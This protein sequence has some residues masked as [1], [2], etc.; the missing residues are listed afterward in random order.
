MDIGRIVRYYRSLHNL[1]QSDVAERSGINEKYL[2]RIERNE[3]VPTIDKVEQICLAF[4]IRLC[5]FLTV[6]F[7]KV[8]LQ[9]K[10]SQENTLLIPQIV[11]DCNCCGCS[12]QSATSDADA[13]ELRCPE[14]GCIFDAE[15]GFI[16]KSIVY[17]GMSEE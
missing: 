7:D 5:D 17:R 10:L 2:G 8:T 9:K 3:S 13:Q 15:N 1:T 11:Y 4:D 6:S 16:E 14:C 12:F